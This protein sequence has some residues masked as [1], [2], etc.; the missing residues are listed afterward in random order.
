MRGEKE[1]A[2]L[3]IVLLERRPNLW[4][5]G[6]RGSCK[7]HKASQGYPRSPGSDSKDEHI[8]NYA[9][10]GS[11]KK[12]ELGRAIRMEPWRDTS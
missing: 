5:Q 6:E 1:R 9:E 4:S 7:K 2:K 10:Q 3:F 11:G 12:F 8:A